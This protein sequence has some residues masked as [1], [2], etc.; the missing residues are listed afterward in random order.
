MEI[1]NKHFLLAI[2]ALFILINI[3]NSLM[4]KW[5]SRIMYKNLADGDQEKYQKYLEEMK[6]KRTFKEKILS[7]K[8]P[9]I[10]LLF[11]LWFL[12]YWSVAIGLTIFLPLELVSKYQLPSYMFMLGWIIFSLIFAFPLIKIDTFIKAKL[13]QKL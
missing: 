5:E 12:I 1:L 9:F 3:I 4:N 7:Q 8:K 2:I 13:E 11:I 6:D 10:S